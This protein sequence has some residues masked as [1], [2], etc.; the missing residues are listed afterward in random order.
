[1]SRSRQTASTSLSA[2]QQYASTSESTK[3]SHTFYTMPS[4]QQ[5]RSIAARI[6]IYST[7]IPKA[8]V[9]PLCGA[10]AGVASGIV[11]CPLDVIKTKLQAQG[12]FATRIPG[13]PT[14]SPPLY[15]GIFGTTKVI[16]QDE[17]IR[18]MY[19]GLGPM[20]LGYLPTWAVYLTVYDRSR[21]AYFDRTSKFSNP[22]GL[23][24]TNFWPRQLVVGQAIF[25]NNRWSLFSPRNQS[26]LG[27]QNSGNVAK[28][29]I[30]ERWNA[31]S[32]ALFVNFGCSP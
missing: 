7:Q 2:Q 24:E 3:S 29:S 21:D 6:Q 20:T 25:I 28:H 23:G 27:N 4:A 8:W 9:T 32:M 18:G 14:T 1:M 19:R 15:R 31:S 26:C 12:G 30:G 16:W 13:R 17:G 11:T 5:D 22:W 10:G